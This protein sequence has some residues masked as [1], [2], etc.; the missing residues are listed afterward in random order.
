MLQGPPLTFLLPGII[1][2]QFINRNESF[3]QLPRSC[4]TQPDG[5][6]WLQMYARVLIWN[7][8]GHV[9]KHGR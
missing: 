3:A 6:G 4:S 5:V 9:L 8:A 7:A 1:T 2:N